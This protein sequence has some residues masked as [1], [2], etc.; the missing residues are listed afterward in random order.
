[1]LRVVVRLDGKEA[2]SIAFI[3]S[4]NIR[5]FAQILSF[6]FNEKLENTFIKRII[7]VHR[8]FS[9]N[10]K[11]RQLETEQLSRNIW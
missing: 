2:L 1:M 5:L 11:R 4:K 7:K 10:L 6:F 9:F 8:L 3:F